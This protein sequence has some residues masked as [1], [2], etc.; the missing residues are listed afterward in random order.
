MGLLLAIAAWPT[1]LLGSPAELHPV[2]TALC[3]CR[4]D[5]YFA[6]WRK[7]TCTICTVVQHHR[8]AQSMDTAWGGVTNT[9]WLAVHG[10]EGLAAWQGL[11]MTVQLAYV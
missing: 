5:T 7:S 10:A 8:I 6:T 11:E 9:V 4:V 3:C 1:S 2:H